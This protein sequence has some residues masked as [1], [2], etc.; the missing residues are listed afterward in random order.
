MKILRAY[1]R[2]PEEDKAIVQKLIDNLINQNKMTP[3]SN[4]ALFFRL[5]TGYLS[6]LAT[7]QLNIDRIKIHHSVP[8]S[9]QPA[10]CGFSLKSRFSSTI[11]IPLI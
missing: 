10:E 9:L 3:R 6:T 4:W 5:F 1:Y 8:E 7:A 2:L 11:Y